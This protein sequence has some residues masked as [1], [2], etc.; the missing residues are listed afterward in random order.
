MKRRIQESSGQNRAANCT[1]KEPGREEDY[2]CDLE[3]EQHRVCR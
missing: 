2:K 1:N 3:C